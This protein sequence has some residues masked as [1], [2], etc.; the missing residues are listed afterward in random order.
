MTVFLA[1]LRAD[2]TAEIRAV[3]FD[4]AGQRVSAL[5]SRGQRFADFVRE[6]ECGLRMAAEIAREL[7][8]R[9]TLGR[10]G[11]NADRREQIGEASACGN[12]RIVPRGGGELVRRS[13]AHLKRRR[14]VN[15]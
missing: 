9:K 4:F 6:H 11:E 14:V 10:V 7:Q 8:R 2:V 13:P 3:N 12:A 1:V 5:V 15:V